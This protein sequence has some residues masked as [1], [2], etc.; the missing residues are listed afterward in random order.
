MWESDATEPKETGG[1][2]CPRHLFRKSTPHPG[3]HEGLD[4]APLCPSCCGAGANSCP[5]LDLSFLICKI[6]ERDR[7]CLKVIQTLGLTSVVST[8]LSLCHQGSQKEEEKIKVLP[9]G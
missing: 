2:R 3:A 8:A 7:L 4:P 5:S 6:Q 9:L 1:K